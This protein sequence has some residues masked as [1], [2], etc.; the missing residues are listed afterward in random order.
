MRVGS[1]V[2]ASADIDADAGFGAGVDARMNT[3]THA[4][5]LVDTGINTASVDAGVNAS[6]GVKLA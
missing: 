6:V 1:G 4:V 5:V 3:A 2:D